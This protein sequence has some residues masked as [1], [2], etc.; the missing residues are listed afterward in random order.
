MPDEKINSQDIR[1][2]PERWEQLRKLVDAGVSLNE[3]RRTMGVD[4]RT[5]RRHFP[6]YAPFERGG[7]GEAAVIREVS[8]GLREFERRGKIEGNRDSGFNTRG[9]VL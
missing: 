1:R 7:S 9:R 4:H 2:N 8:R 3:I 5:L 6:D